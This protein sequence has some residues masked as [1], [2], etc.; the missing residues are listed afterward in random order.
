[1]YVKR[2][3]REERERQ[4]DRQTHELVNP[5]QASRS[6][7]SPGRSRSTGA[8]GSTELEH[9]VGRQELPACLQAW[10]PE[11][12]ARTYKAEREL[13]SRSF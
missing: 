11:F 1:V 3:K 12:G 10:Q 6:P 5:E 8:V 9:I 13:T 7:G 2:E 4:T